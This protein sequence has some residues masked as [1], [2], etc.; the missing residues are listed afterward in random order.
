M[1]KNTLRRKLLRDMW[2]SRMQFVAIILLCA[3]GTWAFSGLDAA[4]R[5]MD[6]SATKYFTEQNLAD[7]WV[8]LPSFGKAEQR[9]LENLPG[10]ADMQRRCM[11]NVGADLP[12][13]PTVVLLAYDGA[14]R[15]NVPLVREGAA[16]DGG[17]LR[18][19]LLEEQFAKAQGLGVGDS[20]P[21]LIGGRQQ[22][23]TVRGLV[24]SPEFVIT[25]QDIVAT[26]ETYGF[27]IVNSASVPTLPLV[28]AALTVDAEIGAA[29]VKR[30]IEA[31]Y[32]AA[33]VIGRDAHSSTLR[34]DNDVAMFRN[35]SYLFPLLAF[36]VAAMIVMTTITRMIENQR[37]QMGTLKALGFRDAQITRHYMCYA[38][39][40]SMVGALLGLYVGRITMPYILWD[41]MAKHYLLPWQLQAP[42][43]W[44]AWAVAG[45]AVLM[46]CL[47]C[48]HTYRKSAR[49]NTAALLRQKPPK[50]GSRIVL[51]RIGP[52]WRSFSFNT[53]M[54]VRNLFRNKARTGMLLVGILC[55]TM[56]IITSMGLQDSVKYFVGQYYQGT[57]HYT[58]RAELNS[59]AGE[60]ESYERR[61]EAER[62][63]CVMEKTVTLQSASRQRT[64]SLT[65]TGDEQRLLWLGPNETYLPL[66]KDGLT[67]TQKLAD[68]LEVSVGDELTLWLPGDDEPVALPV[69]QVAQVNIGQGIY[70]VRS[71]W[72]GCRKGAFT[73]TAIYL[74]NQTAA[75]E[76]R[77]RDMDE[78]DEL[79][80]PSDQY[81]QTLTLLESMTGVFRL[82]SGVALGLA[83][84]VLYNMGIL[85]FM[86]R[87]REYA[88]LK[89]LGY[90]QK[91]I[92]KLMTRENYLVTLLGVLMG[93]LPGRWLTAAVL[94]SCESEQ[95]VYA[96]TVNWQSYLVAAVVTFVFSCFVQWFLT[97]KVKTID[98][99]EALKSIE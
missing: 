77:L 1:V 96:S 86:E 72:E 5:M 10:V 75:C 39:Y 50:G 20:I 21:L 99:V 89:V 94:K 49:E 95:M 54:V 53:K 61:L 73:P 57:L 40:P 74:L 78:V 23:F 92:R 32:P 27:C 15:I 41:M 13:D 3:L 63:E 59:D 76:A 31:M 70:M 14:A 87:T 26:P 29:E 22:D 88:T 44:E 45:A 82:L 38:L 43:S 51:E 17:D 64:S 47:I 84:V 56:L 97:R 71:C 60:P 65:V 7:L 28:Q 33:L 42:V 55:C 19:C 98:M 11:L 48:L 16:L 12:T 37:I 81:K 6:V 68:A 18:G 80:D 58:L 25:T 24:L 52:L 4:W 36:A 90:H 93:L 62:V 30:E 46:S 9:R 69:R 8:T 91:E 67:I 85:N 2:Q 35:L 79:R 66:P 83:F 34:T